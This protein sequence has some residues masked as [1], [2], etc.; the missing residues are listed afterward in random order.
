ALQFTVTD[1]GIGI[2]A[3]KLSSIF[4]SFLQA[5]E[6]TSAR[7]GGTGLGLSIAR[8]LVQLHGSDIQVESESGKGTV[9]SF[10]IEFPPADV[11][12]LEQKPAA[13]SLFFAQKLRVLLADDNAL[14]REIATEALLRHFENAEIKEA[15]NGKEVLDWLKQQSFDLI[16][17]DMQMP[18]MSGLEATRFIRKNLS[19]EIPIIALTASATPEEIDHALHAG[20]NRHL[21]K[22]FK[23]AQLA[24]I[25]ES[26][27]NLQEHDS[28]QAT[29]SE[30]ASQQNIRSR[31]P[32]Y[33]L[34]FLEDFCDGDEVQ[35][36]Y[37]LDKFEAQYPIEINR[38]KEALVRADREAIY[39]VAHGF[40]PQL[41][42][43]GL[44]KAVTIMLRIEQGSR[45]GVS[46]AELEALSK[47][48]RENLD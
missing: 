2:P 37:F 38:L 11:A 18:E 42:F 27:L 45:Q 41:E 23:P 36:Q 8:E 9:F 3:F 7:F 22:P 26:V 13:E 4:E 6:D 5:S 19:N 32:D 31:Y 21:G 10:T 12:A 46:F 48:M 25:I 20:M 39:R 29:P 15:V 17:M 16:L 40:R 1:T 44:H 33:D 24:R 43:V 35:M 14:N 47:G 28:K 34:R 30:K